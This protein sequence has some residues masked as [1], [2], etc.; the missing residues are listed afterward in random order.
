[1]SEMMKQKKVKLVE[2]QR[3]GNLLGL[4]RADLDAILLQRSLEKESIDL[5]LGPPWYGSGFY[6]AVSL[7]DLMG[8]E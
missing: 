7:Y 6:G 4:S 8:R 5:S 1:M 3:L 2:I